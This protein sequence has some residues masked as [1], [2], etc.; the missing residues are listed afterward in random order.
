MTDATS[1]Y[2]GF[3]FDPDADNVYVVGDIFGSWIEPGEDEDNPPM[4][5]KDEDSVIYTKTWQLPPGTYNYKYVMNE[6]WSSP[7]WG[8]EPHRDDPGGSMIMVGFL[9]AGRH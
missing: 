2:V 6:G 5:P 7:E 9:F 3:N 4:S 1:D 8:N